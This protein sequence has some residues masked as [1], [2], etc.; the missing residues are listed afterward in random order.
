MS[1]TGFYDYTVK[2]AKGQ[3]VALRNYE[4]QV[5]LVVN[6]ASK[7]GFTAQYDGLQALYEKYKDQGLT[8]LGFPSNEFKGQEP[9]S[10]EDIQEFCRMNYGVQFPVL[11]KIEVNGEAA[12]PL[13][14]HLKAANYDEFVDVSPDHPKHERFKEIAGPEGREI[15]WNFNKFLIDRQG[16]VVGRYASP[17]EPV[18]LEPRIEA[19]LKSESLQA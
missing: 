10:N 9:G 6:V 2:G 4:G 19:L 17:V 5:V 11:A 1:N 8:I 15:S 16:Q 7:C 12:D 13:Y 14:K 3:D 18:E